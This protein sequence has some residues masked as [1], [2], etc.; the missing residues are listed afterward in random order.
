MAGGVQMLSPNLH[1][2]HASNSNHRALG[3][4]VILYM[5]MGLNMS[6]IQHNTD[7]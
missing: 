2:N 7:Y 4:A 6:P 3:E 5:P 1:N